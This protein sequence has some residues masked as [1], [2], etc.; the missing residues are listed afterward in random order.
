MKKLLLLLVLLGNFTSAFAGFK[1]IKSTGE[2]ESEIPADKIIQSFSTQYTH[3][4]IGAVKLNL[5]LVK[6]DSNHLKNRVILSISNK[7]RNE[8]YTLGTNVTSL[9]SIERPQKNDS[10]V[11]EIDLRKNNRIIEI[12]LFPLINSMNGQREIFNEIVIFDNQGY[13]RSVIP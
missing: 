5:I 11:L 3:K 12:N 2:I 8:I 7:D 10:E 4:L 13:K 6:E 1:N 9:R